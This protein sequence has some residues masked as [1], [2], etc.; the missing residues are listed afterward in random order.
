M[1]KILRNAMKICRNNN[2]MNIYINKIKKRCRNDIMNELKEKAR[3]ICWNNESI[4]ER[5]GNGMIL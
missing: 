2:N 4:K 5:R 3:Q 1:N